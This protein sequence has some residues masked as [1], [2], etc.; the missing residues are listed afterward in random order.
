M[1]QRTGR[2]RC[3]SAFGRVPLRPSAGEPAADG[4][5]SPSVV[6]GCASFVCGLTAAM[7]VDHLSP[8]TAPSGGGPHD[9]E[10]ASPDPARGDGVAL[11]EA[12]AE[13]VRPA[14]GELPAWAREPSA[15]GRRGR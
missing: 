7:V 2:A 15:W 13:P 5:W 14:G 12:F 1:F 3:A 9:V 4:V 8:G 10:V 11:H 6:W